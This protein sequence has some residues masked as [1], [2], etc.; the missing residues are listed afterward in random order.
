MDLLGLIGIYDGILI[1]VYLMEYFGILM[2]Y[3]PS[4]IAKLVYNYNNHS[5]TVHDTQRTIFGWGP[6]KQQT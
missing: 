6:I 5:D 2:E 4:S 3:L 1:V